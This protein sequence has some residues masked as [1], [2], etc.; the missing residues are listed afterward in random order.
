MHSYLTLAY[1][2]ARQHRG[3]ISSAQCTF[4]NVTEGYSKW[5]LSRGWLWRHRL[6]SHRWLWS[7]NWH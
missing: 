6:W 5:L 7:Q 3:R 2:R 4:P 1:L